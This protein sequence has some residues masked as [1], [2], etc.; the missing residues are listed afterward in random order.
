MLHLLHD[1]ICPILV[2]TLQIHI[3]F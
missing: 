2:Q 3:C 1:D